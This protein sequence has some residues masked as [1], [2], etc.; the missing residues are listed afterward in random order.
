VTLG[1]ESAEDIKL[2][3]APSN[4]NY[5]IGAKNNPLL[6][7]DF[8]SDSKVNLLDFAYFVFAYTN[9]GEFDPL[10]D[11]SVNGVVDLV[12][13][14]Q[15]VSQYGKSLSKSTILSDGV[16]ING[17]LE[18]KT[19]QSSDNV[20]IKILGKSFESLAGYGMDVVYDPKQYSFVDAQDGGFLTSDGGVAPIFL[21]K[22]DNGRISI[23][24]ILSNYANE[25]VTPDGDGV[26]A[27]IKLRRTGNGG[28]AISVEN[29]V[30]VDRA[31]K[32]N[33]L[34]NVSIAS[35][36]PDK[37]ELKQNYPNPFNPTTTIEV[38]LPQNEFVTL[39]IY[40]SAGQIVKTIVSQNLTA[41]VYKFVWDGT[42]NAGMRVASGMYIYKIKAGSF[43]QF[44][45][46]MLIK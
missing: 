13:F 43:T 35:L 24:N 29:A 14:A 32:V 4:A 22:D 28:G 46:M 34:A 42:N 5:A 26:V 33:V 27:I 37:F 40:N 31:L 9:P 12:D 19:E 18:L 36:L 17:S 6:T 8:T 44:K 39:A 21:K 45:K 3:S 15:F 16:N 7:A 23:A 11:L 2:S 10:F 41:G 25:A 30:V 38:A 1:K 20:T